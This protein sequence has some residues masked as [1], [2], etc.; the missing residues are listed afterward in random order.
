[1]SI[2]SAF[3]HLRLIWLRPRSLG[4]RK[5]VFIADGSLRSGGFA[6]LEGPILARTAWGGADPAAKR[7]QSTVRKTFAR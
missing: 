3:E 1:V 4:E 5:C 6:L 2:L 7:P